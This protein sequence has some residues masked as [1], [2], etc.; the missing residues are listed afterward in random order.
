LPYIDF[1]DFSLE[2]G[3]RALVIDSG[4]VALDLFCQ[5]KAGDQTVRQSV[6]YWLLQLRF[7]CLPAF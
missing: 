5:L 1:P 3:E 7:N 2:M 4:W 6:F